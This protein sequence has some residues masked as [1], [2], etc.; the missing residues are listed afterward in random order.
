MPYSDHLGSTIKK[1]E[2]TEHRSNSLI[3]DSDVINTSVIENRS[4]IGSKL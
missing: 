4:L 1:T 2:Y 3:A